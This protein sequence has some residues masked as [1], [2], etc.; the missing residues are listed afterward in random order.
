MCY[1]YPKGMQ[2]YGSE[3]SEI[4]HYLRIF[5]LKYLIMVHSFTLRF[6]RVAEQTVRNS[7][8]QL[9]EHLQAFHYCNYNSSFSKHLLENRQPAD[10]TDNTMEILYTTGKGSQ[11]NTTEKYYIYYVITQQAMYVQCSTEECLYNH[12]CSGKATSITYS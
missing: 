7:M 10:T 2:E 8:T 3:S 11:L 6:F 5:Y 1:S 9:N 4:S 12:C